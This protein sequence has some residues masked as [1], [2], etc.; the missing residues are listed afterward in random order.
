MNKIQVLIVDDHAILR[1]GIRALLALHDDIEVVGEAANGREAIDKVRELT[2]DVVFMDIAMPV[3]DGLEATRRIHKESPKV[4]ILILTQYDNR[5]YVLSCVKAGASGCI[6]KR[7]VATELVSALRV[8]HRGDSYL[9]PSVANV[10]L[11]D[12]LRRVESDPY[13]GLTDRER[14]V[15]K[16]VADGR[17][18]KEIAELL[19]ISPKTVLGHRTKIM[20]KLDIHHRTE[21]VKYAIRK[22]LTT[23]DTPWIRNQRK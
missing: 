6:P 15:L 14:E 2:P 10:L 5:E 12:Y 8:V 23:A 7:A 18:T 20:E 17:T 22:G 1:D 21:L 13:D 4:K 19:C 9:Y 16:L 3:M 11:Q